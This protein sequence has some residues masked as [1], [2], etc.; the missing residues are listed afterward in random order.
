MMKNP[1]QVQPTPVLM[2]ASDYTVA[3]LDGLDNRMAFRDE[4]QTRLN[5]VL[6]PA[7]VRRVYFTDFIVQ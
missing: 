5:G 6:A 2:L 7:E 3:E 4:I 1:H